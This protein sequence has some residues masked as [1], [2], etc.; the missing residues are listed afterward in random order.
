MNNYKGIRFI[1]RKAKGYSPDFTPILKEILVGLLL[2][3]GW[4]EKQKINA[5]F[6]F[7]QGDIHKEFFFYVYE[8]FTRFCQ[9]PPIYFFLIIIKKKEKG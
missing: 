4:L 8:Y 9:S 7:E 2:G 5:R 3:D 6:R 1:S